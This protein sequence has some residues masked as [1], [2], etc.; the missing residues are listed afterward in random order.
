[1]RSNTRLLATSL[2]QGP[3]T[4]AAAQPQRPSNVVAARELQGFSLPGWQRDVRRWPVYS[5]DAKRVGAVDALFVELQTKRVRYIAI[6]L[7]DRES[8]SP[9]WGRVL[10]PVGAARRVDDRGFVVL[11]ALSAQQL[12]GAPRLAV[13]P[14][15]RSDEDATLAAFGM[16]TSLELPVG[17]LYC[18]PHFDD[19]ALL[20]ANAGAD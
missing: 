7:D 8:S 4:R 16:L 13:R 12:A 5:C 18:G 20:A 17:D 1:M 9:V 14:V 19:R 6:A 11:D 2:R 10:V 15:T 3:A